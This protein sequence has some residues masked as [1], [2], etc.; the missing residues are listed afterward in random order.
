[1]D[2]QKQINEMEEVIEPTF[3][4]A[5]KWYPDKYEPVELNVY[6]DDIAR[7]LYNAG[8]RKIPKD[9]VVITKEEYNALKMIEKYHVKSCGKNNV[10]LTQEEYEM[11]KIKKKEKHWLEACMSIWKNAKIDARK[12][13]A[14]EILT[15]IGK[16]SNDERYKIW[17]DLCERHGVEVK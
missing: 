14:R 10:V 7:T 5:K 15:A 3:S 8:Y 1:M 12:E 16:A 9:S 13:T 4:Y 2:E 17:Q 11:L 6:P